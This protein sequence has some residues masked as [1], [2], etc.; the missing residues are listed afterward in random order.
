MAAKS[1]KIQVVAPCSPYLPERLHRGVS[2]LQSRG[3]EVVLPNLPTDWNHGYL[4]G[5]DTFRLNQLRDAI[6]NPHNDVVWIA[7]GGYGLTRLLP[8]FDDAF[9]DLER[10]PKIIGFSDVS[11]LNTWFLSQKNTVTFHGPLATTLADEDDVDIDATLDWLTGDCTE[12]AYLNLKPLNDGFSDGELRGTLWGGNLTVLGHLV[13][14]QCLWQKPSILF[15]EEVG[16][17]PYRLDRILTQMT[18]AGAFQKVRAVLL[19]HFTGCEESEQGQKKLG[20]VPTAQET[21]AQHFS[22]LDIPVFGDI[23]C[24]HQNPNHVF[25][26]GGQASI[27]KQGNDASLHISLERHEG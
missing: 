19:G 11:A 14:T 4:N 22:D 20:H 3:H 12:M 25:P 6:L 8:L 13:G 18:Q 26:V 15:L 9:K 7:R 24:G 5:D 27:A 1:L 21:I 17:R 10:C 2:A 23:P 16:E